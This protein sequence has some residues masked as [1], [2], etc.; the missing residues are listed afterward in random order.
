MRK[1]FI[2]ALIVAASFSL[3]LAQ[4]QEGGNQTP[5]EIPNMGRA[6]KEIN[7]VGRLDL[8]IVDEDGR[9]V[10][11]AY[12]HLESERTDGFFC[13]SWNSSD[14]RGVAVLPPIHMGK[15]TL[16]VKAKGYKTVKIEVPLDTLNQPVRVVMA[17][18]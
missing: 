9:P 16:K 7:G 17:R 12:A 15:L 14:D 4:T 5:N 3:G 10:E 18:K 6:P 8:R 11:G 2:A 13:E 1:F